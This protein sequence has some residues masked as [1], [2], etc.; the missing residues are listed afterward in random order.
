MTKVGH[1]T[2]KRCAL[3]ATNALVNGAAEWVTCNY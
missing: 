1:F 2:N 3:E